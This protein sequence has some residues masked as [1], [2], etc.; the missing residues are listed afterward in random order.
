MKKRYSFICA[1]PDDLEIFVGAFI[2][3]AVKQGHD[4]EIVSMTKG[5]WGTMN[6]NL[7]GEKL[8]RIRVGE[9]QRAA[10]LHGVQKGKIKFLGLIDG[11]VTLEAAEKALR[12]YFQERKPDVIFAPEP[13]FSIY[14]HPD[15][16]NTG[17]AVYFLLKH[18]PIESRPLLFTYHSFKNNLFLRSPMRATG[19]AIAE[20]RSQ[21]AVIFYF[22]P[23]RYL[24]NFVNGL[25]CHRFS[26][27]E[28][29]R[30]VFYRKKIKI[31]TKDKILHAAFSLGKFV[32]KAWT[33]E[34][35]S[36]YFPA[37]EKRGEM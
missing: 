33:P 2:R 19:K 12:Q 32:F 34:D 15:H 5:E 16:I 35:L 18:E 21:V 27:M 10:S 14:V 31:S 1:H 8:A 6:P 17:K 25:R 24:W 20:H 22:L 26:F 9:L 36:Q 7:K 4:V 37:I 3:L 13:V 30:H 29:V 28:A 23:I 11:K